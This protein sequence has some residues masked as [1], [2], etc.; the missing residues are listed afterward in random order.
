MSKESELPSDQDFLRSLMIEYTMPLPSPIREIQEENWLRAAEEQV[1]KG[2]IKPSEKDVYLESL[3]INHNPME[4]F[5]GSLLQEYRKD[6]LGK[7]HS[8]KHG[9]DRVAVGLFSTRELNA[10]AIKTPRGN[11]AV[12]LH[13]GLWGYLKT[14]FYC[15]LA[16]AGRHSQ[17]SSLCKHHPDETY[18]LNLLQCI[19]AIQQGSI[20]V[21][22]TSGKHSIADC[23]GP[24][25]KPNKTLVVFLKQAIIFVMLHEYGH[26]SLGHLNEEETRKKMLDD[27]QVEVY[28]TSHKQEYEADAFAFKS[29]LNSSSD[30][31]SVLSL[32]SI[33]LL[34][35][36]FDLCENS[37]HTDLLGTHPKSQDRM[38]AIL[39]LAEKQLS[40]EMWL[41]AKQSLNAMETVMRVI[42]SYK[43]EFTSKGWIE[44]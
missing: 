27:T 44:P 36:V 18:A 30:E 14:P 13:I 21:T 34:F 9:L 20:I 39:A 35:S 3:R 32:T 2:N 19:P 29:I 23:L 4:L 6:A 7:L 12:A 17:D 31:E 15:I 41:V 33:W 25:A 28:L 16:I 8:D 42:K 11:S 24:T 1:Q 37:E 38:K 10:F 26:I 5:Q 22:L 40:S 43:K